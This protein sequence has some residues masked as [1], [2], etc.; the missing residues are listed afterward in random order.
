M[1]R[2]GAGGIDPPEPTRADPG[3]GTDVLS[4]LTTRTVVGS[5]HHSCDAVRC[6]SPRLPVAGS[7][8]S[9]HF[10]LQVDRADQAGR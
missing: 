3:R 7:S 9:G 8:R 10:R 5:D 2:A 6:R 4:H 1:D